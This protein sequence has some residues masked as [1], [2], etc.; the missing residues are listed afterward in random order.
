MTNIYK[1]NRLLTSASNDVKNA[2]RNIDMLNLNNIE[3]ALPCFYDNQLTADMK[4][5]HQAAET[6][7]DILENKEFSSEVSS[8]ISEHI[9][10]ADTL[11]KKY[12]KAWQ[13][14]RYGRYIEEEY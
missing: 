8:I 11:M 2:I 3:D 10:I 13:L 14:L 12:N 9:E 4:M 7:A 1:I 6:L 5:L